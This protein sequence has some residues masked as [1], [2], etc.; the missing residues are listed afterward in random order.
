[1][2]GRVH[3]RAAWCSPIS[4]SSSA[5]NPQACLQQSADSALQRHGSKWEENLHLSRSPLSTSFPPL[6]WMPH[7]SELFSWVLFSRILVTNIHLER[8]HIDWWYKLLKL[9]HVLWALAYSVCLVYSCLHA[10]PCSKRARAHISVSYKLRSWTGGPKWTQASALL[11]FQTEVHTTLAKT[12]DCLMPQF[13]L[14][15]M[16]R[17]GL[18]ISE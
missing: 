12:P 15:K 2:T 8:C 11:L 6:P 14:P 13:F 1:M 16:R 5:G 3:A 9:R 10:H 18:L 7:G 17:M 4:L